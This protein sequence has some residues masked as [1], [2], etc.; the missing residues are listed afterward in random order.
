[1]KLNKEYWENR[2]LNQQVNWDAGAITTPL[3]EY[4]DQLKDKSIRI[5]IPGA[6]NSY[7]I[8]YLLN[9][10]FKNVFA[11]DFAKLPLE[12]I[13]N[14]IPNIPKNRLIQADF[15]E[16]NEKY[17]LI[18]EQTFFCALDPQLRKKYVQKIHS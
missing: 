8:E 13:K 9:H 7:E 6:G 15:F 10:G 3:K 2:Y 11:L 5:L 1:M 16:H 18:V 12:N 17:D 14:R 4:F